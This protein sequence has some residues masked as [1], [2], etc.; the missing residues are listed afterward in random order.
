MSNV[1]KSNGSAT[2]NRNSHDKVHKS[3]TPV[4]IHVYF[5]LNSIRHILLI[6][7]EPTGDLMK[8]NTPLAIVAYHLGQR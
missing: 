3:T 4:H 7:Q 1:L 6:S 2:Q 5:L 8:Y